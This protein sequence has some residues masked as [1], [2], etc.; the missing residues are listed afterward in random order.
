[1]L[2]SRRASAPRGGPEPPGSIPRACP[3]PRRSRLPSATQAEAVTASTRRRLSPPRTKPSD[4]LEV[5]D[6][7]WARI[8][9]DPCLPPRLISAIAPRDGIDCRRRRQRHHETVRRS[10]S[11]HVRLEAHAFHHAINRSAEPCPAPTGNCTERMS[12]AEEACHDVDA[13][14]PTQR[15]CA[16]MPGGSGPRPAPRRPTALRQPIEQSCR[17]SARAADGALDRFGVLRSQVA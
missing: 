8:S 1:M 5:D 16:T 15:Q 6:V 10:N 3:M 9:S 7:S 12:G 2:S 13:G 14:L 11:C 17:R 4:R